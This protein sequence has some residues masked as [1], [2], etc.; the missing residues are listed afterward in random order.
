MQFRKRS[1]LIV[2]SVVLIVAINAT[3]YVA[4]QNFQSRKPDFAYLYQAG[5][6][7]IHERFPGIL[8]T[9]PS[10]KGPDFAATAS[11][12]LLP[13]D[14]LHPPYE[15]AIYFC[16]ALMKFRVA[17]P[18]WWGSNLVL[19]GFAAYLL[20]G[21]V[22]NL[23]DKYPYFLILIATFFPVFVALAQGQTSI[24]LLVFLALCHDSLQKQREFRAGFLLAMGMFKFLVVVPVAVLLILEKRWKSLAGFATGCFA[25]LLL[26][27][28]LVG[29]D[30]VVSWVRLIAGYGKAAPEKAGTVS[31]MPNLRGLIEAC[32]TLIAPSVI[33]TVLTLVL[34]LC[35][36]L[37]VDGRILQCRDSSLRFSLQVLLAVMISYHLYPHDASVLILPLA[38][39]LNHSLNKEV[40]LKFRRAVV[41]LVTIIYLT[42][43]VAHLQ[44]GM[45]L[46][47]IASFVLL[48]MAQIESTRNRNRVPLP[49]H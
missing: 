48:V 4:M 12:G 32:G 27:C 24:L 30:G 20:W 28:A 44:V 15:L 22:P 25:L 6:A 26:S 3:L 47:G 34:S 49:V 8:E 17:Y 11:D 29:L 46:I 5:R 38:I 31:I 1:I 37:W 23:Q 13:Q 45:P 19:L 14:K 21:Y 39:L 7:I 9:F 16:L 42:P 10:L 2:C 18:F 43:L 40:E 41:I 35:L 33:L 36:F